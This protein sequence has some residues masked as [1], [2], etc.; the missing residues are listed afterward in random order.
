MNAKIQ[1]IAL[2]VSF[3]YGCL[4]FLLAK[5]NNKIIEKQKKI[6]RSLISILFMCNIVLLYIII[7]FKINNGKFHIYFFIMI[8]LGYIFSIHLSQKLLKNVKCRALIEKIKQKCYTKL[9][10]GVNK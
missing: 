4:F 5:I 3:I 8:T 2:L 10:I 6:Y 1:I 9:K 7:I